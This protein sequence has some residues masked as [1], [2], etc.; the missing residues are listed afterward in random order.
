MIEIKDFLKDRGWEVVEEKTKTP[1]FLTFVVNTPHGNSFLK[2]T[3]SETDLRTE[4]ETE[5]WW[6][7][8]LKKIVQQL[9][10]DKQIFRAPEVW[11]YGQ[12]QSFGWYLSEY[13]NK[14]LLVD[15]R[16]PGYMDSLERELD[17]IVGI[18]VTLD[19]VRVETNPGTS[20]YSEQGESA[21]YANLLKKVDSWLEKPLEA[22]L[23]NSERVD[24]GKALI[25]KYRRYVKPALQHGDFVPWHM[26]RLDKNTIGI[27]D[28]EHAS[29]I[30]PRFYDLAYLYT[31]LYTKA[32]TKE[33]AKMALNLFL[34][35][36]TLDKREFFSQF[37]PVVALRSFGMHADSFHD[38][39]YQNEARELLDFCLKENLSVFL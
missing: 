26:F 25:E 37:L 18:L 5:I 35:K 20:L 10:Q 36:S 14:P 2:V 17:N 34:E 32:H 7:L 16:A 12:E 13:F 1:R 4:I 30:K 3:N 6:N 28:G 9:P 22:G 33:Q 21:P 29:L 15:L 38:N 31:R 39:D 11:A 27:V 8:T 24:Q 23:I 19:Q